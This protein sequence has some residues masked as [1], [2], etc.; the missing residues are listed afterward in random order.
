METRIDNLSPFIA[1]DSIPNGGVQDSEVRAEDPSV[2]RVSMGSIVKDT[3]YLVVDFTSY[4]MD[5]HIQP[6]EEVRNTKA[7]SVS[8][9]QVQDDTGLR[10]CGV[11]WS[12]FIIK[13]Y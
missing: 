6:T 11:Y 12:I 4:C 10:D 7:Y 5:N 3:Q 9:P 13:C 2:H 8:K 1:K